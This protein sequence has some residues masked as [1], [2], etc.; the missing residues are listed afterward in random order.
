MMALSW[1]TLA[2]RTKDPMLQGLARLG[3]ALLVRASEL[4][5]KVCPTHIPGEQNGPADAISYAS[6]N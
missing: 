6:N 4:L 3:A 2:A 5:T 1:M